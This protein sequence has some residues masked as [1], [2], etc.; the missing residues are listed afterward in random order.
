M[1]FNDRCYKLVSSIP[2]GRVS[3]YKE[4]AK[5]LNSKAYRAVGNAMAKNKN[6]ITI[7]CHRVINSNGAIGGYAQGRNKKISLLKKEG[8]MINNNKVLDFKK[9]MYSYII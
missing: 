2:R 7:P 9:F 5:T 6:L 3:T 8:I 4:I 1:D